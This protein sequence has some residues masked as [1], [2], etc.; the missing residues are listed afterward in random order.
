MFGYP[1]G[2]PE[3]VDW[4]G[5]KHQIDAMPSDAQVLIC[6]SMGGTDPSNML[7]A[8]GR[9]ARRRVA[10]ERMERTWPLPLPQPPQYFGARSVVC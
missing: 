10:S 1:D 8:L 9:R 6:S 5:Q 3:A 7:N 4:L 2:E